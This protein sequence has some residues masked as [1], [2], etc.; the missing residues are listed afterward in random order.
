MN[1]PVV[2]VRI[3]PRPR[4][5]EEQTETPT[6]SYAYLSIPVDA[7]NDT[8]TNACNLLNKDNTARYSTQDG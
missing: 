8:Q 7:A 1:Q 3:N 4:H 2:V 6:T 5:T